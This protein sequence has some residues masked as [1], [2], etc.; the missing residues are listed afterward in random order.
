MMIVFT[1][2]YMKPSGSGKGLAQWEHTGA[3]TLQ[4]QLLEFMP[5]WNSASRP[6]VAWSCIHMSRMYA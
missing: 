5:V 2:M 1:G 3:Q 4:R 6:P